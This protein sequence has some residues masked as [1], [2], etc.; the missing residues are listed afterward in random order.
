MRLAGFGFT[1]PGSTVS[2]VPVP[3]SVTLGTGSGALLEMFI[4]ALKAP[5]A[6]GENSMLIVVLCPVGTVTGSVGD[7]KVKYFVEIAALLTVISVDPE[8]VAVKI[9]VFVLPALTLPKSRV[10]V[11]RENPLL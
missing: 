3:L 7:N 8:L 10:A 1:W 11:L 6:S 4:V 9:S 5:V 2:W